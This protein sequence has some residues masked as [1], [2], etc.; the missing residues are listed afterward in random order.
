MKKTIHILYAAFVMIMAALVVYL[1]FFTKDDI[2]QKRMDNG[3][4][5]LT[6]YETMW[7]ADDGIPVGGRDEVLISI[8]DVPEGNNSLVFYTIH[9]SIEVYIG[10]ELVYSLKPDA[11]NLFGKTPGN[12]WSTI[13][14]FEKDEG[15]VLRI[16]LIPVYESSKGLIP[17][18]YFGS[19]YSIYT[20]VIGKNMLTLLLSALAVVV[21]LIF[22][23]FI[24]YNYRNSEVDKSLLM[25]GLFSVNIGVW[26][27]FDTE[28]APLILNQGILT[29]VLPFLALL[30]VVVP[31]VLFVKDLFTRKEGV[32]WDLLCLAS[33]AVSGIS[34]L[35]QIFNIRD[36]RETLWMNHV[37][38]AV[39]IVITLYRMARELKQNGWNKRL[40]ITV[41]CMAACLIGLAAD[42][43]V[44]YIFHGMVMMVMGMFGF[45][46]YIIILG[47]LSLQDTKRLMAV[48]M[49][50]RRFRKMAFHDQL[51]GLYNRTAYVDYIGGKDFSA[52][53]GIVIMCDLNNL[54]TC[55][56]H[57]GHEV[58]D[59]YLLKSAEIIRKI[60]SPIGRCFRMGGDEFCII[61]RNLSLEECKNK[62]QMLQEEVRRW[63]EKNPGEYPIQ[64]ACGYELFD[65]AVDYD[66]GDTL[67][68]ADKMMYCEKIRMKQEK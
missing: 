15:Q 27:F 67:R 7:V 1:A 19:Q 29:S 16:E 43:A 24:L 2:Y 28:T 52:E 21:G 61:V 22:I 47:V 50:A 60:F 37:L 14:I 48:G 3:Y 41:A 5:M 17:E 8:E 44:F 58:G 59:R 51:T 31:F 57:Y 56:D 33:F 11:E 13:P 34:I 10:N 36:F 54:K 68:R 39:L 4:Q 32:E 25:L 66:I 35:L 6:E 53:N 55:N 49:Q 42:L 9:Q 23:F 46:A 30:M 12:C 64:I 26:K 62:V 45:L 18:F 38:M 20:A 63:N 40:K 65:A